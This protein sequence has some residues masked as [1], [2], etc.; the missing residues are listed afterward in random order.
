M[1]DVAVGASV[2][3]TG[4]IFCSTCGE[5]IAASAVAC[6]KCGAPNVLSQGAVSKKSWV[7]TL[8]LCFFFGILGLHRFYTGKVL[9]GILQLITLGGLGIWTTIDF[10]LII[11][12]SF[13][14]SNGLPLKR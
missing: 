14:D 6:P 3:S 12:G 11:V 1:T 2:I 13:K 4:M 8:L 10:I 7:S 9:T 5:K